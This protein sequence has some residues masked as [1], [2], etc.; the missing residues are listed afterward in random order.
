MSPSLLCEWST[1]HCGRSSW[2]LVI[3]AVN[4]VRLTWPGDR[5]SNITRYS[6]DL[7]VC[8]LLLQMPRTVVL[9]K[10]D[11]R[12]LFVLPS[13]IS[14]ICNQVFTKYLDW[15]YF[16]EKAFGNFCSPSMISFR[17]GWALCGT[18]RGALWQKARCRCDA[19][20]VGCIKRRSFVFPCSGHE[21]HE[22]NISIVQLS[23]YLYP[24][25]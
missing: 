17:M 7:L 21:I 20:E 4:P 1:S 5:A 22:L 16:R 8:S 11:S 18:G 19:Y 25:I 14:S 13:T 23:W 10:I 15:V 3:G 12:P 6:I 24:N 9:H 2:W